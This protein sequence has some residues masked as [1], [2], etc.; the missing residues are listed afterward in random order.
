MGGEREKRGRGIGEGR[1]VRGGKIYKNIKGN[2]TYPRCLGNRATSQGS[3]EVRQDLWEEMV[4][5]WFKDN[6]DKVIRYQWHVTVGMN[7][8]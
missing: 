1:G 8:L 7:I 6:S 5:I 3:L 2:K 4:V